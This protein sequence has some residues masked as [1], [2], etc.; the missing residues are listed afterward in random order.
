MAVSRNR[1]RGQCRQVKKDSISGCCWSGP[2]LVVGWSF[3]NM[4]KKKSKTRLALITWLLLHMPQLIL[5]TERSRH[6]HSLS[7][8]F[9]RSLRRR[10]DTFSQ[11]SLPAFAGGNLQQRWIHFQGIDFQ[12]EE[13]LETGNNYLM[14]F[15]ISISWNYLI[16][17]G[18]VQDN[19]YDM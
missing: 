3:S 7:P 9:R 17:I 16:K 6:T 15:L 19:K 5:G 18:R 13:E 8:P 12:K 4:T 10:G 11:S 2:R 1:A 14:K